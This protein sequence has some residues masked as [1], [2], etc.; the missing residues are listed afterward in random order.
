MG[1]KRRVEQ[2]VTPGRRTIAVYETGR[3]GI[4]RVVLATS[5][6]S[7][8]AAVERALAE[9]LV[10]KDVPDPAGTGGVQ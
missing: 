5:E 2:A 3:D 9:R 4:E 8:V 1:T 10:R 7:V 6:P